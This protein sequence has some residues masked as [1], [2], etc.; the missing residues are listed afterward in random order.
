MAAWSWS[1]L[2]WL[3]RIEQ[4]TLVVTG[5]QDRLVP[6]VNSELIAS[7]IPH[8]RILCIDDWGH[9]VLLD[10][11]SGAGRAIADFLRTTRAED[12]DAWR[13]GRAVSQQDAAASIRTH[14]N[15]L[16]RLTWPHALYRAWH[17][18]RV[19]ALARHPC[20]WSA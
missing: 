7:R 10:R 14:R 1:S 18:R 3:H 4:P 13:Q 12:S 17:A 5:A 8:A 19:A 16:T 11:V 20:S 15:L 9:Y 6:A 2:P